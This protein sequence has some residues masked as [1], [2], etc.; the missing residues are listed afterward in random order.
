MPGR[1]LPPSVTHQRTRSGT[2]ASRSYGAALAARLKG[3]DWRVRGDDGPLLVVA[4]VVLAGRHPGGPATGGIWASG[5][6][7]FGAVGASYLLGT[8][9]ER[10]EAGVKLR[11]SD[12]L[13]SLDPST[14]PAASDSPPPT[15]GGTESTGEGIWLPDVEERDILLDY[16][17]LLGGSGGARRPVD[18]SGP[19]VR[20]CASCGRRATVHLDEGGWAWCS[21]CGRAA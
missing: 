20:T 12:R 6:G 7:S 18:P 1:W 14:A 9:Y 16:L 5:R 8:A 2:S 4:G 11:L 13:G 10:K 21:V 19:Q 3:G 15:G 17:R